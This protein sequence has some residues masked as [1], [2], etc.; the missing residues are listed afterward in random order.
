MI[1]KT[2]TFVLGE[3]NGFL[4]TIFPSSEPHA[5][6]SSLAN[7]DGSASQ[8][9]ENKII[10]SLTNIERETAAVSTPIQTRPDNGGALRVSTPLNLNIFILLSSSFVGNYAEALRFLSESI[11]FFQAKPVYTPQNSPGFPR[12][13]ERL[14]IEM[15]T[16]NIQ[17]LQNLWSNMGGRYLPSAFYKV[18]MITLP[19]AWVTERIPMVTGTATKV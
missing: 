3:L 1:D 2:L 13:L 12:E 16:L 4:G 17:D 18:R 11:R 10:V 6:L 5:V 9:T 19:D 15:V 14:A 8:G 7:P